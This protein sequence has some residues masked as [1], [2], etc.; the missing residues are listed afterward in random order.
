[1]T[2]T[3][4]QLMPSGFDGS[5]LALA[6]RES[7]AMLFNLVIIL[8]PGIT[9][10]TLP[11]LGAYILIDSIIIVFA[12]GRSS[13]VAGWRLLVDGDPAPQPGRRPRFSL[14]SLRSRC[15]TS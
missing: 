5:W 11:L 2:R 8:W 9:L 14:A 7:V 12:A 10:F 13:G 3:G 1:M 6:L 4:P 15:S